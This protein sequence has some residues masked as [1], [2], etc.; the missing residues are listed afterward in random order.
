MDGW[1]L[2]ACD[3]YD[4]P[5]ARLRLVAMSNGTIADLVRAS[6]TDTWTDSWPRFSPPPNGTSTAHATFRGKTLYWIAFSS[7]RPYGA[8]VAGSNTGLSTPQLWFAAITIGQS[9]C[10]TTT[11][12]GKP[13]CMIP[14]PLSTDPSFSPVWLPLQNEAQGG[15]AGARGNHLPQWVVKAVKI[16]IPR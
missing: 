8:V 14:D 10:P 11:E 15:A 1:G 13:P 2:G 9:T 3:S 12:L 6:G 4:D 16:E 7:R 5:S